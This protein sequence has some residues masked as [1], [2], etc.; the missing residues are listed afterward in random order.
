[1]SRLLRFL[2]SRLTWR[3]GCQPCPPAGSPLPPRR[4]LVL[5]SITGCV[6]SR[7]I[8]LLEGL[9][10]LKNPTTL[11]GIEPA[12]PCSLV[13]VYRRFG[14]IYGLYLQGRRVTQAASKTIYLLLTKYYATSRKIWDRVPMR[15][16][17]SIYLILPAV[18]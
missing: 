2:D 5:I 13:K 1:M 18:L 10:Q 17:F 3:A 16:I 8:M 12:T 4:F 11:S 15:W 6:D 7:A 9:D 14:G